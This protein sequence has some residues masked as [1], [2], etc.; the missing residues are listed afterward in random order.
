VIR[1]MVEAATVEQAEQIG[2]ALARIVQTAIP[3]S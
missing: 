1:V 2:A 3:N